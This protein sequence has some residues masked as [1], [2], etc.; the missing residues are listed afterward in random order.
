MESRAIVDR[1][2]TLID[3]IF[4]RH[5]KVIN[6]RGISTANYVEWIGT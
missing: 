4:N 3:A 1:V 5:N 2:I 6:K